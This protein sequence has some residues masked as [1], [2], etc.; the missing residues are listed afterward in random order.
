MVSN[1]DVEIK[2]KIYEKILGLFQKLHFFIEI[3]FEEEIL[4]I[5]SKVIL[6]VKLLPDSYFI[7]LKNYLESL[8]NN[9]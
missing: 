5:I 4:Q 1:K 3:D 6:D 8:N 2:N 7:Y 9:I